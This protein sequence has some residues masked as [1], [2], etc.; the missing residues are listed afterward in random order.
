[1]KQKLQTVPDVS[2]KS[3][4]EAQDILE[5]AGFT[6]SDGGEENSS[7]D[8]GKVTR[9]DPAA[10]ESIPENSTVTLY[11]SSGEEDTKKIPG[12]LVG[13]TAEAAAKK[14]ND[15]GFSNVYMECRTDGD[16]IRRNG[17]SRSPRNLVQVRNQLSA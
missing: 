15:A 10:G 16:L 9:T 7:V 13:Q 12:G 6:V 2:G 17:S 3:V 8:K 14:L 4:E 5:N 1:M 11:R